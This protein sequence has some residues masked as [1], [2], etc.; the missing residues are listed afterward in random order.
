LFG[1]GVS[2][3]GSR[4]TNHL[5]GSGYWV[6][7]IPLAH[8]RTSVGIVADDHLHPFSELSSFDKALAWLDRHEPQ[9]AGV[10]RSLCD[11][12]M[13][14]RALRNYSY[15]ARQVFSEDRWGLTGEAGVFVDPLYSPGSDFIAI[16][17]GFLTD[18]VARDLRGEPI[19]DVAKL[20]DQ[21]YRSFGRTFLVTY[22]RQYPLFGDPRV[23]AIKV[24]WDFAMYWGSFA[25]LFFGDKLCDAAVMEEARP[26]LHGFAELNV[27]M[28]AFFRK[29]G[30][31]SEALPPSAGS[32]ID[33]AELRFL[34]D[35]NRALGVERDDVPGQLARNLALSTELRGEILYE[36]SRLEPK[37]PAP[38]ELPETRH[39]RDAFE[40]LRPH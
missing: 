13:D 40:T 1:G 23:M 31:A 2:A 39:L 4:P 21:V 33:Y 34:S 17:N 8:G 29:W 28:Q 22:H 15:D 37:L 18:L 12:R 14:F 7:I 11:R 25:P 26:L 24:V 10:V 9:C 38:N 20:Y 36:A 6:W 35:L 30:A 27:R 16:A 32:V 3:R 19:A 5:M